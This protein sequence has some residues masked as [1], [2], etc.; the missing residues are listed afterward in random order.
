VCAIQKVNVLRKYTSPRGTPV[1]TTMRKAMVI[2][3]RPQFTLGDVRSYSLVQTRQGALMMESSSRIPNQRT[4]CTR[5][6]SDSVC[7][8]SSAECADRRGAVAAARG[9]SRLRLAHRSSQPR[10]VHRDKRLR[11]IPLEH[12]FTERP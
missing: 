6:V 8:C 9:V 4:A 7:L 1:Q 10:L 2:T 5:F 11:P 12:M 3:P